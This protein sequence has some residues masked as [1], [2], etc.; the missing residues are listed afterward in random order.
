M[1]KPCYCG[2]S[3]KGLD[4]CYSAAYMGQT[5]DQQSREWQLI[6]S[7]IWEMFPICLCLVT[8]MVIFFTLI[9]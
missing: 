2:N 4:T 3:S 9:H 7:Y 8:L 1:P 5:R 6:G